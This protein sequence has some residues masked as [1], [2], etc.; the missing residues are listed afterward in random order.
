MFTTRPELSGTFGAV[1]STHWLASASGMAMLEAGGNAFDAVV[2]AGL[3]LQV[4]EPHLNGPGGDLPILYHRADRSETRVVCA[5]GTAP[6]GATIDHYRGLGFDLVPA[7]GL[8]ATVVPGAFDGWMVL[9]RDH[10]TLR[11]DDVFERAIH[12]AETGIPV[13]ERMHATISVMR[14]LFMD[15]WATSADLYLRRGDVPAVGSFHTNKTLA[16]TWRRLLAEAKAGGKG[17]RDGEIEAARQ[18]WYGGFVADAIDRFCREAEVMDTSGRRHRGVLTG[19]DMAAWRAT[20]EDPVR[21][22]YGDYTLCKGGPW[23]Q[24]PVFLQQLALLKGFDV[25]A[26]DPLGPEFI[27]TVVEC[28]KLAFADREAFYGDPDFVD[29]PMETLLSD[30]YNAARRRLVGDEASMEIRPGAIEGYGG[31]IDAGAAGRLGLKG[32]PGSSVGYGD[33]ASRTAI[34]TRGDTCHIDVIDKDGNMVSATPSGGWLQSSP[35]IPG[36]GFP[37][38]NRGQIFWLD[39]GRP[40]SLAPGKRPRTTLSVNLCFRGGAPYM[41]FGTPGGD[42]QDQWSLSFFLRHVHH[43]MNLQQAIDAPQWQNMHF[44]NSF[45]PRAIET[46]VLDLEARFADQ[47]LD[48]LKGRGHRAKKVGAWMLGRL[49]AVSRTDGIIRAAANPRLMQGYAVAR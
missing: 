19:A 6:A 13:V 36:L 11:L 34:A 2:A 31:T 14:D 25:A 1:A 10:G 29:V 3:V 40:A 33:A 37:L 26:M 21:Y 9:L 45:W 41:V 48:D 16:A 15:E 5:Q 22:D 46:G 28:A 4:A 23:S 47:T 30:D 39:E 7:T 8:L 12:Y 43:G 18:T 38:N 24:G 20:Y 49:S 32:A 35:V 42:Q 44:L 17:D 27:H